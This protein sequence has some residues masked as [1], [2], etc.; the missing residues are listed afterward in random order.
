[1]TYVILVLRICKFQN[2]KLIASAYLTSFQFHLA[3]FESF[4]SH[5]HALL[6]FLEF[7][8]NVWSKVTCMYLSKQHTLLYSLQSFSQ[9]KLDFNQTSST[10]R[11]YTCWISPRVFT[12][13]DFHHSFLAL[14]VEFTTQT[15]NLCYETSWFQ[16]LQSSICTFEFHFQE[17]RSFWQ[18]RHFV[19][20]SIVCLQFH[21]YWFYRACHMLLIYFEFC[22]TQVSFAK[23][24]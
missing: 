10:D 17:W 8:P 20:K 5:S 13:Q 14:T 9:I 2:L 4:I 19:V 12:F 11:F 21:L 16:A 3:T 24:Q 6:L 1:M 18:V 22:P 23:F 15:L 7:H